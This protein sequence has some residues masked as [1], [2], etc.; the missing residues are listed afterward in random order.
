MNANNE[1]V[2]FTYLK[3]LNKEIKSKDLTRKQNAFII[4]KAMELQGQ[5][6]GLIMYKDYLLGKHYY[7]IPKQIATLENLYKAQQCYKAI[8]TT[9]RQYRVQVKNPKFHFKYAECTYRLSEQ[10]WCLHQQDELRT[11]VEK[12]TTN[13]IKQFP[14]NSSFNWLK[15]LLNT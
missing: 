9:A 5:N 1:K 10:V 15:N 11:L 3:E 4:L 6:P 8:F 13:G 2:T 7:L 14:N 12:L